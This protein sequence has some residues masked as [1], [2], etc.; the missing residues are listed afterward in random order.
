MRAVAAALGTGAGSLYRYVSSR[1]DLLDLMADRA[2]G[3][4]LAVPAP[5]E[6]GIEGML[7]LARQQRDLFRRHRW[8]LDPLTGPIHA[9]PN[10]L[11][12]FDHCLAVL[13]PTRAPVSASFEAIALTTGLASTMV[14]GEAGRASFSFGS[15]DPDLHSHL[16]RALAGAAS[17]AP[18]AA[19]ARDLF[20]RAVRGLLRGLLETDADA[21]R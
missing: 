3:E 11:A 1:S 4:L 13:E 15:V 2:V 10:A 20:D 8:L 5:I 7:V 12:W 14:R 18:S 17:S 19:P 6:S 21:A 9:G 16:D